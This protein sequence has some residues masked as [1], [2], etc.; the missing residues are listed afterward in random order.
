MACNNGGGGENIRL[1]LKRS[2][3]FLPPPP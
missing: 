3:I 1:R 2:R